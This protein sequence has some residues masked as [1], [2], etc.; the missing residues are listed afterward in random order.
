MVDVSVCN[1]NLMKKTLNKENKMK[2]YKIVLAGILSLVA[3]ST[4]ASTVAFEPEINSDNTFENV[5]FFYNLDASKYQLAMFNTA[6]LSGTALEIDDGQHVAFD[7]SIPGP[8]PFTAENLDTSL[9]V[10]GYV[11][12][13]LTMA[14]VFHLGLYD[15]ANDIWLMVDHV[16]ARN[17][18]ETAFNVFFGT[19][20]NL[21]AVDMVVS[22]EVP[23]PAA[24]WLFG[25]GL[26]GLV[27]IARRREA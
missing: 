17:A 4:F 11:S 13:S 16:D 24:A 2:I 12:S 5:D 21:F 8:G 26:I 1:Q 20:G 27:G 6:D 18:S 10:G 15:I 9:T 23:V 22:S 14:P 19:P 3:T 7:P 25:S